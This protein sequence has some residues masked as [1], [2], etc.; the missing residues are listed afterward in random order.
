MTATAHR[1]SLHSTPVEAAP[2][3]APSTDVAFWLAAIASVALTAGVG[4]TAAG[5]L[6]A[7]AIVV[8]PG[9]LVVRALG[10]VDQ[11]ERLVAVVAISVVSWVIVAHI[12]LTLQVWEP[13]T[14][15]G[16]VLAACAAVRIVQVVRRAEL[17]SNR[18]SAR[19]SLEQAAEQVRRVV[20]SIGGGHLA[21][22]VGAL[23]LWGSSVARLDVSDIG[24]SGLAGRLPIS[25]LLAFGV[26]VVAAA[27]AATAE[28]P[29]PARLVLATGSL[30][31]V[32]YGTVALSIGT[33]RYP[34]AYKHIGVMRLLDE[35]GRLHPDVDIYN[36]FS[37]FFGLGALARGATGVDPTS[38][39]A[40]AQVVGE[41]FVVLA[42]GLL[43]LRLTSSTRVAQLAVVLYVL[44]NWVGQ[45]YFAAQTL[46]SFLAIV[47]LALTWSWFRVDAPS[48]APDVVVARRAVVALLFLGLLMVH[49]LT[50]VIVIAP[51]ALAYALKR[52]HDRALLY[53]FIGVSVLWF[54]RSLPYFV[55]QGFDL[56][57]GGS[58]T[59]N[60]DGNAVVG[61][62]PSMAEFVG[63]ATRAFSVGV[64]LCAIVGAA[65]A[66]WAR[67]R[68][69]LVAVV[70]MI[71]FG[72]PLVQSYGGEAI[73]RVYLYSLPLMCA[74]IAWGIVTRT[75]IARRGRWPQP[76]ILTS[77]LCLGLAAGM[78]MVHYGRE[79]INQVEPSEVAMGDYIGDAIAGPAIVAQFGGGYPAQSTARY[80]EFQVDDTYT[81]H[82]VD[83]VG[84]ERDA[85]A[86]DGARRRRRRPARAHA[87]HA[88]RH[89]QPGH[90]RRDSHP[91]NVPG[92][93]HRR[94]RGVPARQRP[95]PT[96]RADRRHLSR[97][98]QLMSDRHRT[99]VRTR[100]THVSHGH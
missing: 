1:P 22:T 36:N 93:Q 88:L 27:V 51:V 31:M 45:N 50:P 71:P 19:Q 47:V 72:I 24:F 41:G 21:V 26:L 46:G 61:V 8:H 97:G 52:V 32:V 42:V 7:A 90:D 58:P 3:P 4:G 35:T 6:F 56:G 25:W 74:L 99:H 86:V 30:I 11:L 14:T 85:A 95:L 80:P 10:P 66:A 68:I 77:V 18:L 54:V 49:P 33:V 94:R 79:R 39:A 55:G 34:W 82:I 16:T 75:P 87:G 43:V 89:R 38:Y 78:V 53:A 20:A 70:A 67:R 29:S 91:R 23:A 59:A 73:Y 65:L 83:M 64:W 62:P 69:G 44:T 15:V 100:R 48:V 37:G 57:F 96:R 98:G 81:P 63:L 13:R 2:C 40:W 76:T 9:V 84:I 17:S 92:P 5:L 12:A 60:A 28:R